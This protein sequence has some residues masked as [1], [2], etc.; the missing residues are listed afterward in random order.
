MLLYNDGHTDYTLIYTSH[1]HA[2]SDE[3]LQDVFSNDDTASLLLETG[4]RIPLHTVTLAVKDK[5]SSSLKDYHCLIKVSWC[6]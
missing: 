2:A 3:E 5:I 1:V 4:F 6:Y